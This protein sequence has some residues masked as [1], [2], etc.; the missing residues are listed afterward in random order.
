MIGSILGGAFGV[1]RDRPMAVLAWAATFVVGIFA[2]A[3][4]VGLIIGSSYDVAQPL[5]G[6]VILGILLFYIGYFVLMIVLMNAVYRTVLRPQD[7][8]FA[9]LRFGGDEGRMVLLYIL[10]TIGTFILSFIVNLILGLITALVMMALASS[11]MAAGA[12]SLVLGLVYTAAVIWF[13]IRISLIYP[14]SFHRRRIALDEAWDLG[15]G[16]FWTLFGAFLVVGIGFAAIFG[17]LV[18]FTFGD[19][20][21]QLAGAAGS[22]EMVAAAMEDWM[23]AQSWA[24]GVPLSLAWAVA[25]AI[26]AVVS[27]AL[28]ASAARELL[29]A[30]G[31]YSEADVERAAEIFE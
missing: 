26:A 27:P 6:S 7:S 20:I 22:P 24:N 16:R 12:V 3:M 11:P 2:L 28:L 1:L 29:A 23:A 25:F 14:V 21:G 19:L 18:Y 13:S 10:V 31:E 17:V 4:L 5:S 30:R 8:S 9:S 15:K